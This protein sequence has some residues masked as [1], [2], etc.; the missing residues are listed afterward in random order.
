MTTDD[1][2]LPLDALHPDPRNA[3]THDARNLAL[4]TDA[5]RDVG[6]ARSIVVDETGTVLAGNATL[7]AAGSA[8]IARVRIVD[9]DGTELIAVRRRGLT[10]DQK[11]RLA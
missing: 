6:A 5:L 2:D 8:G 11:Q 10:P 4:I 1:T 7:A 9:A 3:R